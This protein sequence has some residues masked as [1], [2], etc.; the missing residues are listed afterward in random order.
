MKPLIK[1]RGRRARARE[2]VRTIRINPPGVLL[3]E[4]E[5]PR[6]CWFKARCRC[7]LLTSTESA[8]VIAAESVIVGK[9]RLRAGALPGEIDGIVTSLAA[10]TP[11]R[12]MSAVA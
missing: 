7:S 9:G 5:E 3:F 6:E 4:S 10:V 12:G 1:H 8:W 2:M 11:G